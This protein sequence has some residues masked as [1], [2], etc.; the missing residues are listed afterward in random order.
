MLRRS[1]VSEQLEEVVEPDIGSTGD[2]GL[3][4][5]FGNQAD[6]SQQ[7][8][9]EEEEG[10]V[11]Q[12]PPASS[13]FAS[14]SLQQPPRGGRKPALGLKL[15]AMHGHEEAEAGGGRIGASSDP[16]M[17]HSR[18]RSDAGDHQPGAAGSDPGPQHGEA[19][20]SHS[21]RSVHFQLPSLRQPAGEAAATAAEALASEGAAASSRAAAQQ[22]S[23]QGGSGGDFP[24]AGW[25]GDWDAHSVAESPEGFD[26][27]R[28][29]SPHCSCTPAAAYAAAPLMHSRG[30][31]TCCAALTSTSVLPWCVWTSCRF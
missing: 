2:D 14:S 17:Q 18:G 8:L 26:G 16:G 7:Q 5:E 29:G 12:E 30:S 13:S 28:S 19:W 9:Q 4:M 22:A 31:N 25:D 11:E 23:Q 6:D 27:E 21:K 1:V 3:M 20:A 15:A 10:M 24:D